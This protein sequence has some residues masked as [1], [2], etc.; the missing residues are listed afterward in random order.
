MTKKETIIV[1]LSVTLCWSS[2]YIFIKDLSGYFS[3]FAYLTLTSGTA[4][5]GLAIYARKL[6]RK[7][8]RQTLLYS[9]ILSV[10]ITGS[11]IFEKLS[12][13][14]LSAS[15]VSALATANII[16]VPLILIIKKQFPTRNNV[17]GIVILIAGL[18]IAGYLNME[19]D[20]SL[21]G[22][23]FVLTS[24][25]FM[26]L[27]TVFGVDYARQV[28]PMLLT[29]LQL[30]FTAL[31][32]L[33]LWIIFEPGTFTTIPLN[34]ELVSYIVIIAFFSKAFAY[35][36]LM[37][38][39]KYADALTVTIMAACS[40]IVTLIFALIIPNIEGTKEGFS[41]R[42]L[43]GTCIVALGAVVAGT[44]FLSPKKHTETVQ[45]AGSSP[46]DPM[47]EIPLQ[48]SSDEDKGSHLGSWLNTFFS[49]TVLFCLLV[50][51]VNLMSFADGY[52]K[53]RPVNLISVPAGL[54]YGPVG[55]AACAFGNLLADG[56]TDF[57]LVGILGVLANFLAAYLPYKLWKAYA[58]DRVDCHTWKRLLLYIWASFLS[59]LVCASILTFG[60]EINFGMFLD[61]LLP[62]VF[63]NNFMFALGF[64][65]PAF[66]VLSVSDSSERS[67]LSTYRSGCG[68]RILK[69]LSG[70]SRRLFVVTTAL[71][72]VTGILYLQDYQ[73]SNS[74][75]MKV[76]V[77]LEALHLALLCLIPS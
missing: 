66:I 60:S 49:I 40:P 53:L 30:L 16:L 69:P 7:L 73:W 13:D 64:G 14:H 50:A 67:N 12:L 51:S 19:G 25:L 45:T 77:T 11:L 10:F 44:D 4:G 3:A 18:Y 56:L 28:E 46:A 15:Q 48:D 1:L 63:A 34:L 5:I 76:L 65:L 38:A 8:N 6:F 71:F 61:D 31:F 74:I 29:V 36:M 57:G 52:S 27:Y 62:G 55:A 70:W 43:A 41:V 17:V 75:L 35:V 58:G 22:I 20:H 21:P 59:S 32:A 33:I 54:L 72:S 37:Y 23:L 26:S 2:A 39:E 68:L 9:F 47:E 42:T 24:C